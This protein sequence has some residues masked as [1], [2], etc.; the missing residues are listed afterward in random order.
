MFRKRDLGAYVR[1]TVSESGVCDFARRWPC[2]GDVPPVGFT[3]DK[4]SGDLV[5]VSGDGG[6][7]EAG[8]GALA[9]DAKAYA[10]L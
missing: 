7:D 3:F 8:V 4:G 2:F 1:V 5:D 10:G 6:M 9:D